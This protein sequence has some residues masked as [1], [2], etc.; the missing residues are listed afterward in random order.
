MGQ[1]LYGIATLILRD[2]DQAS[3]ATQEALIAAWRDLSGLRDADR[4][5]AWLNRVLVR[6]CHREARRSRHRRVG[7][8]DARC[9]STTTPAADELPSFLDRDQLERGFR[10]LGRRA[11]S[12]R[13]PPPPRGLLAGRDRRGPR[14]AARDRQVAAP[15]RAQHDARRARRGCPRGLHRPGA[16]RMSG[17]VPVDRQVAAW[18][19]AERP[20]PRPER[21]LEARP[22]RRSDAPGAGR[23]GSIADRWTWRHAASI[24]RSPGPS[25][26]AGGRCLAG[27]DRWSWI[28]G[29]LGSPR[30]APP[31]GAD[32]RRADRGRHGRGDRPQ[33]CGWQRSRRDRR[34]GRRTSVRRGRATGCTSP[35]GT[36]P[37]ETGPWSL[38]VGERRRHR[39]VRSSPTASRSRQREEA[40]SQP[41][42]IAWSPDSRRVAF[43]ADTMSTAAAIFVATLGRD[44]ADPASRIQPSGRSTLRGRREATSS[45]SRATRRMTL[46][47]VA[48]DGSGEHAL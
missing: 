20:L 7:R 26:L 5:G 3:D 19:E 16:N 1:R 17:P 42:N 14:A 35:T 30:P 2:P 27:R 47:V 8:D 46:H 44:G 40:F 29:L 36:A 22:G 34:A 48:P 9:R 18:L 28:A 6:A 45:R 43:A 31:F 33:Q 10:R 41:S 13:R 38:V 37:G 24:A 23:A 25:S 4:F 32:P 21:L 11:A 15:P 39:I 12:D